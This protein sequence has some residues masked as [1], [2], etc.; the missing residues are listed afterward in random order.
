M[1]PRGE[2][3]MSCLR[4]LRGYALAVAVSALLLF[5]WGLPARAN[6]D[7]PQAPGPQPTLTVAAQAQGGQLVISGSL[8]LGGV[9]VPKAS[10]SLAVDGHNAGKTNTGADGTYSASTKLP[11]P[12]THVVTA[13][14]SGDK[15]VG[16][17][18]ATT[19]VTVAAPP[20]PPPST[21]AP[22]KPPTTTAAP[23]TTVITG[24]LTPNPVA[25]GGILGVTGTVTS[26]GAPVDL[27]SL[28]VSCDFGGQSALAVTDAGGNFSVNLSLPPTGQPPALTVTI[29]FAGDARF[30]AAKISLQAGVTAAAPATSAPPPSIASSAPATASVSPSV[31]TIAPAAARRDDSAAAATFS[32]VFG[33]VG[34]TSLGALGVLWVLARR[35]HVLLPGERRGFGSDFGH[36][37][38]SA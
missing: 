12:G 8:T 20:P 34:F 15:T 32:I 7:L 19:S 31:S 38:R 24:A 5:S 2:H 29:S 4:F 21:T 6:A 36:T 14:F 25:A 9:P 28:T 3:V 18:D 33:I 11:D 10:I 27:S 17:A 26:G 23:P 16:G 37:G 35:R 1:S 30:P 13:S 22:P